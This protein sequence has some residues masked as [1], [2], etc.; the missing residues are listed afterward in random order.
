MATFCPAR[1]T[2]ELWD[3]YQS[4]VLA[5]LSVEEASAWRAAVARA[6]TE[7]TSF[8]AMPHHCVAGTKP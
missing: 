4:W 3:Y 7:G 1:D 5:A 6:G 8:W 2:W